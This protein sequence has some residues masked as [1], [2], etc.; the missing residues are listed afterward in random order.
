MLYIKR[1]PNSTLWTEQNGQAFELY[2]NNGSY[3]IV[4]L[5]FKGNQTEMIDASG[6]IKSVSKCANFLV[7]RK[8]KN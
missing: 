6:N 1:E 8:F 4:M 7:L 2:I 3:K 5:D